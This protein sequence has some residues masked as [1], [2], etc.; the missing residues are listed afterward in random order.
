MN[1]NEFGISEK[2][3]ALEWNKKR[4]EEKSFLTLCWTTAIVFRINKN[5]LQFESFD[6]IRSFIVCDF[7]NHT[8]FEYNMKP[9]D[10][11]HEKTLE[12]GLVV[13]F[14]SKSKN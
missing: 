6:G 10:L 11:S 7:G 8:L 1:E 3:F 2:K 5:F 9:A 13:L 12:L 4:V 14:L